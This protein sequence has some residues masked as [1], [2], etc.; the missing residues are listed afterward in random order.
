MMLKPS[1]AVLAGALGLFAGSASYAGAA[2]AQAAKPV[3]L[4]PHRAVYDIKLAKTRS[5]TAM[6]DVAGRMVY[7]LTGS[8][9]EGFTQ[10]MRFVTRM[11]SQEG[12]V[13]VTDLRSSSWEDAAAQRFRFNSSQYRDDKLSETTTGDASRGDKSGVKVEITRPAKKQVK[14]SDRVVF[15]VQHSINLLKAAQESQTV[16]AADLYDGSEK[17]EKIYETTAF[18]G[19]RLEPGF[20]KT[21][22]EVKN[23]EALASLASWPVS[24][25]YFDRS[26]KEDVPSYELAFVFF[27][28]GVSQKLFI[29]YGE[30][31]I[32]GQLMELT[33]LDA[34][35]CDKPPAKR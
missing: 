29:D 20:S 17:G 18:I 14:L 8:A 21:L 24:L 12:N 3:V 28:N 10:N 5:G 34:P 16:F 32:S 27:E 11:T 26:K 25:S 7:E 23:G 33:F 1:C 31:A 9:C 19:R 4:A 15:P 2:S 30:F 13:Q 6:A 35:K 22:P